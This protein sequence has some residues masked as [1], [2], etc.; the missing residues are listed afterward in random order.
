MTLTIDPTGSLLSLANFAPG[1]SFASFASTLSSGELQLQLVAASGGCDA[2]S[3]GVYRLDRSSTNGQ[4]TLTAV[5]EACENRR[6]ALSRTWDRTLVA[7]TTV[8]AGMVDSFEPNFAVVLPPGQYESRVLTDFIDIEATD[9][10]FGMAV[11]KNPQGFVDACDPGQV[12]YPY[13]PGAA[14]FVDYYRQN[15]AFTVVAATPLTIDGHDAIHLVTSP[16]VEGARCPGAELYA[17]TPKE[18]ECHF[19]GADDSFYLVDVDDDVFMFQLALTADPSIDLPILQ[20]I[21]IPYTPG[22]PGT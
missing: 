18:C 3:V 11:F 20:S 1:A 7:P 19:F 2:G 17:F 5:S 6:A 16:R 8:G 13:M 21:R 9:T 10:G 12:R 4:M 22:A 14:A 15:D